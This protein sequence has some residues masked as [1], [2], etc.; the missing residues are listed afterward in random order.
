MVKVKKKILKIR[1]HHHDSS[2]LPARLCPWQHGVLEALGDPTPC[3]R[4]TCSCS[5]CAHLVV[6]VVVRVVGE[7]DVEATVG[8]EEDDSQKI[9]QFFRIS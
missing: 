7:V 8:V 6:I 9:G 1:V 3:Q 4:F 5:P 2:S